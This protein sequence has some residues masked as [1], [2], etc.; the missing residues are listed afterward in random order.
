[1]SVCGNRIGPCPQVTVLRAA[2]P[3]GQ[4]KCVLTLL[5]ASG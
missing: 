5:L 2:L 3:I 4:I 1:M